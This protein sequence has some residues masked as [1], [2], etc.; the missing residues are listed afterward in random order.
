MKAPVA[1]PHGQG[2]LATLV[3]LG[4]GDIA[5]LSRFV[6]GQTGS[7]ELGAESRL[8]WYL[9]ENPARDFD[10]PL[11]WGLRSASGDLVGCFLCGPQRYRFHQTTITLMGSSTFYVDAVHRGAGGMLFLQYSR[12]NARWAL[13]GN[14]AN[15][16]SARLWKA[17]GAAPIPETDH[18]LLGVMHWQPM[19]EELWVRR[20]A[21]SSGSRWIGKLTSPFVGMVKRLRMGRG[22]S[23]DLTLLAS[24]EQGADL[25]AEENPES[26]TAVRDLGFLH[27]R[28]FSGGKASEVFAF[29]CKSFARD[30]LVT[31]NHVARGHRGQIRTL[32][33]L[34]IY[35]EVSAE[36]CSLIA[37][38][39]LERYRG[40]IDLMVVRGQNAKLQAALRDIGFLGREFEAPCGWMLDR[41][42]LLPSDR[43][44]IVPADGDWIL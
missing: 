44:Y 11:G 20:G 34:D 12:L 35:P 26:L 40:K 42:H 8:R 25:V 1:A 36:V 29:R 33:L 32:N 41:F 31:V 16:V 6:E 3:T 10:T 27:W 14:S 13:F 7:P 24:A 38:A 21:G 19:L 37:A 30:V 17:R 4:E 18:E 43:W 5:E 28:Y 2:S 9:L 39:L 23:A 15:P 22:E